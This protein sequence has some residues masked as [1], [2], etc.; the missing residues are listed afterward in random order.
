MLSMSYLT[1]VMIIFLWE[2]VV[3]DRRHNRP[4]HTTK[5]RVVWAP[6]PLCRQCIYPLLENREKRG[7]PVAGGAG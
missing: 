4:A 3:K 5:K 2:D 6:G 1:I 7:T